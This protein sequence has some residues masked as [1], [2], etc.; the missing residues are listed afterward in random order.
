M[1]PVTSSS[2][3][4]HSDR[5]LGKDD[6]KKPTWSSNSDRGHGESIAYRGYGDSIPNYPSATSDKLGTNNNNN[7]VNKSAVRAASHLSRLQGMVVGSGS[8]ILRRHTTY[9][10][11]A[12][13]EAH[14]ATRH[15]HSWHKQVPNAN[16][17]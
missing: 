7:S 15:V 8:R 9:I 3:I 2:L 13:E 4:L 12:P 10:K 11:T 5:S 17:F 6:N 1:S 16:R 14:P